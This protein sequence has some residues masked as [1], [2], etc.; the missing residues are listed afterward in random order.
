MDEEGRGFKPRQR[1]I[2]SLI[3]FCGVEDRM[4]GS[5]E[6]T[7]FYSPTRKEITLTGIQTSQI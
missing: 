1:R 4:E 2:T 6:R 5:N 7:I 3:F